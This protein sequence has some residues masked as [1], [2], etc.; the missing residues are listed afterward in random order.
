MHHGKKPL[1]PEV[2]NSVHLI[3]AYLDFSKVAYSCAAPFLPLL[4]SAFDTC[5]AIPS[6]AGLPLIFILTRTTFE[7]INRSFI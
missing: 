1:T 2:F 3:E 7:L 4:V 6:K 5:T